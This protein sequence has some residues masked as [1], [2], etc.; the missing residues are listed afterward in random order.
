[1]A[2]R[3]FRSLADLPANFGPTA[4]T[5]GNF[6]GVHKGHRMLMGRVVELARQ[7]GWK[8][9]V[10]TFDP[11][12]SKV[13]APSRTPHLL[14]TLDQRLR[15]MQQ[16]GIAEV[17]IAPF[18]MDV[19]RLSPREFARTFLHERLRARAV[20]VGDN[21]RFGSKQAGDTQSLQSLG[22]EYGF[23]AEALAGV[24]WRGVLVS[25]SEIRRRIGAG[26]IGRANRLL[27]SCYALEGDVVSG[28]GVGSTQ[29]VP[30]L[31]LATLA[32]VLPATGVY[33]TRTFDLDSARRWESITNAGYR[34][35]FNGDALTI[36]TFLLGEFDGRTPRRIR[37]EF[38]R[39]VREERKFDSPDALRAQILRD[40][41]RAKT[42]FRRTRALY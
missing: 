11:H 18:T 29:T 9:A 3:V 33:V 20:V 27:E 12:P 8:P 30:T 17:V 7:H 1:M 22:D 24:A 38:L 41:M 40:V 19:A 42:Y 36:E 14:T 39:R 2:F 15:L 28:H 10:L 26:D 5:I 16:A 25:S 21:F 34:P 32:E 13:V 23:R 37:V 35:T 4:V 6:D 31:N